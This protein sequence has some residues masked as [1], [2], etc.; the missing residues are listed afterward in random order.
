MR[1][2]LNVAIELDTDEAAIAAFE[3]ALKDW[4]ESQPHVTAVTAAREGATNV[5]AWRLSRTAAFGSPL[6]NPFARA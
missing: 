3:T 1:T 2:G 6:H 5:V 4:L